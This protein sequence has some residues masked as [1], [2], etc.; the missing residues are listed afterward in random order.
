[1]RITRLSIQNYKS[2][3]TLGIRPGNLT[4]LVGANASGKSNFADC[5][6]FISDVYRHGLELA[7]G[8]KGG[9]ENI[10]FRR[11]R[12]SKSAITVDLC[13]EIASADLV[14]L[15]AG[16]DGSEDLRIKIDHSFSFVARGSSIRAAFKVT[17]EIFTVSVAVGEDWQ[18]VASVQRAGDKYDVY[19]HP[20]WE[21]G[22]VRGTPRRNTASIVFDFTDL[23][24]FTD[25]AQSLPPTELLL[26]SAGRFVPSMYSFIHLM[27]GI[28]VFQI[29]PTKTREFGVPTPTPELERV[30]ANL[31]AVIDMMRKHHRAE[32]RSIMQVMR[33]ILPSLRSIDVDYTSSRTL[34]IFFNED[35]FGRPWSVDEV[36]D[37]TVQTLALLVAIFDPASTALVIEEPENSVHPWIIRHV[38]SACRDASKRKQIFI[39]THSPIVMNAVRPEE[40]WVMWR[41][42]G[43][44]HIAELTHLDREFLPMWQGGDISTFEYIDS[45]AITN[46]LPPAPRSGSAEDV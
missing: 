42:G 7:V 27:S 12:R 34:G 30:G 9:Y 44:S 35:G 3:K 24:Y 22:R 46:A 18:N 33:N 26:A 20:D 43:E 25:R 8:R 16:P 15:W 6:D 37:G 11:M 31:P 28:R 5:L 40:V 32:W 10:A 2:L 13:V 21:G 4:V 19:V 1:M 29:S 17:N 41:S 38:L 45:G 23:Q 36:S 14:A 39:T